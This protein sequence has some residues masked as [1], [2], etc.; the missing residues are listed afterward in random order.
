[1][2]QRYGLTNVCRIHLTVPARQTEGR[3]D[4]GARVDYHIQIRI[5]INLNGHPVRVKVQRLDENGEGVSR[6]SV[7]FLMLADHDRSPVAQFV[8]NILVM[9]RDTNG[10]RSVHW[11]RRVRRVVSRGVGTSA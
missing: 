10:A 11:S 8:A 6:V 4:G 7:A 3:A 2:S 1:M 5:P 9:L